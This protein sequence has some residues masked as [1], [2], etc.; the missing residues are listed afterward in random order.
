[1]SS[2]RHCVFQQKLTF[3]ATIKKLSVE[4]GIPEK[5]LKNWYYEEIKEYD[6]KSTEN[7]ISTE[8]VENKEK[9]GGQKWSCKTCG[10]DDVQPA[11]GGNGKPLGPKSKHF[12]FC[13][14]CRAKSRRALDPNL[15]DGMKVPC[16]CG[17]IPIIPWS[18]V[19]SRLNKY[20]GGIKN[21]EAD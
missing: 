9:G 8:G 6:S 18:T 10:K 4:S 5:T 7:G 15:K 21:G 16:E 20:K 3:K 13:N 19:E 14:S 11:T 2:V 17:R 1:M 12:G